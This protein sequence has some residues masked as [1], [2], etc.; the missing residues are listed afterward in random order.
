LTHGEYL[1][2]VEMYGLCHIQINHTGI[3]P[4]DDFYLAGGR[5]LNVRLQAPVR[6]PRK[7]LPGRRGAA[8]IVT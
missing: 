6:P 1:V 8:P 2:H 5:L 7:V 3:Y 4:R